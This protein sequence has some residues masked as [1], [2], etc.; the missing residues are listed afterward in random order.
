MGRKKEK[1][2]K[3]DGETEQVWRDMNKNAKEGYIDRSEKT[4]RDKLT[5]CSTSLWS[6]LSIYVQST[7]S[8]RSEIKN[9]IA[10][11]SD[12]GRYYIYIHADTE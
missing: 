1:W 2:L 3:T 10:R 5:R 7:T 4:S 12:D 11:S 8:D 6:K 9:P